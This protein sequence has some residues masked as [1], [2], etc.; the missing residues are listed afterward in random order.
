MATDSGAFFGALRRRSC[1]KIARAADGTLYGFTGLLAEGEAYLRWVREGCIGDPP[2]IR[3]TKDAESDDAI[4]VL[5]VRLG[6]HPEQLTG[7]GYETWDGAAYAAIGSACDVA[8]GALHAGAT[9]EQAVEAA[10]EHSQW[11][12][13]PVR[14]LRH[15]EDAAP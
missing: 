8:L 4:H 2:V 13:G 15:F 6:Q 3:R 11:A 10:I 9:A 7:Y 12:H 14:S 1:V 5:R